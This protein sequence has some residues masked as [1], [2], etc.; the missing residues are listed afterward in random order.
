MFDLPKEEKYYLY[1]LENKVNNKKLFG[2][3]DAHKLFSGNI[4]YK[5]T[6]FYFLEHNNCNNKDLQNDWNTHDAK[7]FEFKVL[8]DFK[9]EEEAKERLLQVLAANGFDPLCYNI[10]ASNVD[11]F[12]ISDYGKVIAGFKPYILSETTLTE[13]ELKS[14]ILDGAH[15]KGWKLQKLKQ[16]RRGRKNPKKGVT[17]KQPVRVVNIYTEEFEEYDSIQE[18]LNA[19]SEHRTKMPSVSRQVLWQIQTGQRLQVK[20]WTIETLSRK[21]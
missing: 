5:K 15:I 7:N 6:V 21:L 4:N 17:Q 8:E 2:V 1:V 12:L 19:M 20:G 16:C 14:I 10:N 18:L 13:D 9:D 11:I 3:Y